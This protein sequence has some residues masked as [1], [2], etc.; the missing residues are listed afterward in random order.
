MSQNTHYDGLGS[1]EK[2][3]VDGVRAQMAFEAVAQECAGLWKSKDYRTAI[4]KTAD[5]IRM[6]EDG[7][8]SDLAAEQ[9]MMLHGMRAASYR[10]LSLGQDEELLR[11]AFQD[12]DQA[13]AYSS[14]VSAERLEALGIL[15]SFYADQDQVKTALERLRKRRI[16]AAVGTSGLLL[17]IVGWCGFGGLAGA[18]SG[19]ETGLI[20]VI[21]GV[22]A[23]VGIVVIVRRALRRSV[24]S[25]GLAKPKSVVD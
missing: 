13:I 19:D 20:G 2:V 6:I 10:E 11:Y 21:L 7:G 22:L 16:W 3:I 23:V 15:P 25:D 4:T 12:F 5:A 8:A 18:A 1:A 17:I 9:L 24:P 14:K